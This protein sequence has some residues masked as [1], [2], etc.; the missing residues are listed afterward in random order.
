[1][2]S[3]TPTAER[4]VLEFEEHGKQV[5]CAEGS[6]M[7]LIFN[8]PQ[9]PMCQQHGPQPVALLRDDGT[10]RRWSLVGGS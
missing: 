9:G 8:I 7:V 10:F 5:C 2:G 6:I 3:F 1:M 4:K